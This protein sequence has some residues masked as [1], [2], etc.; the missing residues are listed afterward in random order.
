MNRVA[1]LAGG[2]AVAVVGATVAAARSAAERIER[3]PDPYPRDLLAREPEGEEVMIR[4]PDGT[5]LRAVVAGDGPT[6][7]LAHG[8]AVANWE[9]NVVCDELTGRGYRVITFD[10]RGHGRST[11]GSDGIGSEPMAADYLAVLEHF[12]VH[13]GVLVGHSMGG[14]VAIRALLDHPQIAR[15]LRGLV[16][17]ATWAGRNL[18]G[19]PQN[20]LQI[21]ML[22]AGV[23]QQLTRTKTG[24]VLFGASI[25][26]RQPSPAMISVF[27]ERFNQHLQ[28]HGPHVPL[29]RAFAREDRYP[30]LPEITVPT[31]VMVGEADRTTPRSHSRRLAAGIPRARLVTVPDAGH[32][33]NWEGA[34][35]LVEVIESLTG[36]GRATSDTNF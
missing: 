2:L 35:K 25:C 20:R 16:L 4:R 11:L 15:R 7:V 6:V 17:F 10:Q 26:G 24:G 27:V 36:P 30:R 22:E 12:D 1:T 29:V 31:V 32:M 34:D 18:E 19:A 8:Y 13:D 9:W 21:P 14:F 5:A 23:L 28:E 33:L 3:N